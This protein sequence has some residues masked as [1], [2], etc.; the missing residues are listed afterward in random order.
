MEVREKFCE[1]EGSAQQNAAIV[2][3]KWDVT[4]L[5]RPGSIKSIMV[6]DT[7]QI[8]FFF[9]FLKRWTY[10]VVLYSAIDV[11]NSYAIIAAGML[12]NFRNKCYG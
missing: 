4:I 1:S 7:S 9:G 8:A 10:V 12:S 2:K 6:S 11:Q 5:L 3:A